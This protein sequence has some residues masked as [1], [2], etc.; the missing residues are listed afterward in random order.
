MNK[1]FSLQSSVL[2]C[3]SSINAGYIF[4]KYK[5]PEPHVKIAYYYDNF[6]NS[7]KRKSWLIALRK[8]K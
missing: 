7:K 8:S 6:P 5:P 2:T 3:F 1:V 4:S